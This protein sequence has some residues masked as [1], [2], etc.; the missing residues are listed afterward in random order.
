MTEPARADCVASRYT[1]R[2]EAAAAAYREIVASQ[3]ML[4]G[5]ILAARYVVPG[6]QG[7]STL[8]G[9]A[10]LAA[11]LA[12]AAPGDRLVVAPGRYDGMRIDLTATRGTADAPVIIDGNHAATFTGASQ[13]KL[14]AATWCCARCASRMPP[15]LP[16]SSRRPIPA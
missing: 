12:S 9:P 5:W 11:A 4:D 7:R 16:S 15:P 2:L 3:V 8:V 10:N 1:A 14:R 13:F 6:P